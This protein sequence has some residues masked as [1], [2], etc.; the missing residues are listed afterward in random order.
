MISEKKV[1][2]III[3][4]VLFISVMIITTTKNC[5]SND[6]CFDKS[7]KICSIA[8]VIT[9]SNDNIYK[10]QVLGR[11]SNDCV[12]EVTLVKLSETQSKDLR[13]ALDGRNMKCRIPREILR[14]KSI[15][16]LQNLNDYCTGDLKEAI[17]EITLDKMYDLIVKNFGQVTTEIED[18]R[19]TTQSK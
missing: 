9:R 15:K 14:E 13:D 6:S 3:L 8:K 18:I 17:L 1:I 19:N 2:A 16:D 10:Y 11:K 7:A 4:L 5:G 12:I